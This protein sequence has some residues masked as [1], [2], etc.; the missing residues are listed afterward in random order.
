MVV[1]NQVHSSMSGHDGA[2]GG[3]T[4]S[5]VVGSTDPTG[6]ERVVTGDQQASNSWVEGRTLPALYDPDRPDRVVVQPD[7][8]GMR[9]SVVAAALFLAFAAAVVAA[10]GATTGW[11]GDPSAP[12]VLDPG[13]PQVSGGGSG[14]LPPGP[15]QPADPGNRAAR[16]RTRSVALSR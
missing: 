14:D 6:N 10:I 9:G 4:F 2:G 1:D 16:S 15:G 12:D 8:S 5:P 13:A 3:M 7:R 11:S